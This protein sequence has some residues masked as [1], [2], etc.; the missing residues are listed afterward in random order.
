MLPSGT[1]KENQTILTIHLISSS[2]RCFPLNKVSPGQMQVAL[3]KTAG[4]ANRKETS[5]TKGR[6]FPTSPGLLPPPPPIRCCSSEPSAG[7]AVAAWGPDLVQNP[8]NRRAEGRGSPHDPD[9]RR[10]RQPGRLL[11]IAWLPRPCLR[12]T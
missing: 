8:P 3:P 6:A 11:N 10:A 2:V 7:R 1:P 5:R 4:R 12:A 9:E